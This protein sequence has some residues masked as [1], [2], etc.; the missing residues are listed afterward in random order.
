MDTNYFVSPRLKHLQAK[1]LFVQLL[2]N[3]YASR[4]NTLKNA[5]QGTK[6]V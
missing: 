5:K 4:L 6:P 3:Q 1:L 2:R